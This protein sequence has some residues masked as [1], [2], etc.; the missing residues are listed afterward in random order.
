MQ[1]IAPESGLPRLRFIM[2]AYVYPAGAEVLL[3][4]SDG[5]AGALQM[6]VRNYRPRWL[7][8]RVATTHHN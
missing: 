7:H 2:I 6:S 8:R 1:T 4:G 5:G 3:E